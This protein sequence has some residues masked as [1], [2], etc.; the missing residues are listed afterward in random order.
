[1]R[2]IMFR[3]KRTD[4]GWWICGNL[5]ILDEDHT[6]IVSQYPGA[7]S[8]SKSASISLSSSPV[9]PD[10][11]SEYTGLEDK[12]GEKIFEGDIVKYNGK[13]HEVVFEQRNLNAYFGIVFGP[14]ETWPLSSSVPSS[15][16]EV[17]GNRWDNPE[18]L[19]EAVIWS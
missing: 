16:M 5:T 9:Y 8:L 7:S 19:R 4:N 13:M 14:D 11:V 6:L 15:L 1:M 17:I 12:N 2:Q 18:L 10:T 3:G